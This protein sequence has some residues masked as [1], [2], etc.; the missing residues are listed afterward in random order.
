[1]AV[2]DIRSIRALCIAVAFLAS[3][4]SPGQAQ[5]DLTA[6]QQAVRECVV[7]VR[8][9]AAQTENYQ[10]G[11]PPMWRT[12][13]AYI[14]P[15]GRIHNNALLVGQQE[16]VYRF[17]KCLAEHGFSLGSG[18]ANPPTPTATCTQEELDFHPGNCW[19]KLSAWEKQLAFMGFVYGWLH[20]HDFVERQLYL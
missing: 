2:R 10:F 11:Q 3:A 16:G 17:E 13:D 5:T 8:Q 18:A 6:A 1:M 9:E 12:F 7:Q 20:S 15:D 19:I 14:S 4:A